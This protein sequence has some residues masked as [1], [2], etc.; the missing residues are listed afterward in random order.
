ML[1]LYALNIMGDIGKYK[2]EELLILISE[3][4]QKKIRKLYFELDI[5]RSLYA[6]LLI[7]C[8]IMEKLD[9]ENEEIKF[10]INAY[11]KPYLE[12]DKTF[13]FNISHSGDWV[14]CGISENEIG[15][16]IEQ[17]KKCE[18]GLA[19]RF[20]TKEEYETL[21]GVWDESRDKLF[22]DIWCMKESYV[23]YMG[24]G[25]SIPLDSFICDVKTGKLFIEQSPDESLNLSRC[26]V[27]KEYCA[28]VCYTQKTIYANLYVT[29][30][31][32][33]EI[34]L[35]LFDNERLTCQVDTT[36]N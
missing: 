11:G 5:K 9:I 6:E 32:I 19:K 8:L 7:R 22:Y 20:F 33:E 31:T 24:L 1:E 2:Y 34:L 29:Y 18:I 26:F 4:K 10:S 16:D 21:L 12:N 17:I 14:F 28:I 36:N 13:F 25:M 23:K 35:S 3:E 15:V 30:V 27:D